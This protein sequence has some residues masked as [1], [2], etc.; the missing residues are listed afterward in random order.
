MIG[1]RL[2]RNIKEITLDTLAETLGISKQNINKW[3]TE[4]KSI[5][6]KRLNQLSEILDVPP[7]M[8]VIKIDDKDLNSIVQLAILYLKRE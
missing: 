8:L 1:L 6:E 5:P 3:E 2:F 4:Q 7:D